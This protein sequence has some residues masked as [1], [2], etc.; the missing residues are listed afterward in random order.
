MQTLCRICLGHHFACVNETISQHKGILRI[1]ERRLKI[2]YF[3]IEMNGLSNADKPRGVW[4]DKQSVFD[5]STGFGRRFLLR[6]KQQIADDQRIWIE[7]SD[8]KQPFTFAR[9]ITINILH[10]NAQLIRSWRQ[11]EGNH[12]SDQGTIF[13]QAA[14][15][16]NRYIAGPKLPFYLLSGRIR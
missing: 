7:L 4:H 11:I 9:Q 16:F 14:Q 3:V 1:I 8:F 10:R 15:I 12:I 2:V 6:W 5:K 13:S